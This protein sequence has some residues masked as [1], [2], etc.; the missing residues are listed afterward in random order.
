MWPCILKLKALETKFLILGSNMHDRPKSNVVPGDEMLYFNCIETDLISVKGIR[1]IL[2]V[3]SQKIVH[4]L[5][6]QFHL[7]L[8]Q[9]LWPF[10]SADAGSEKGDFAP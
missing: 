5:H 7:S 10:V 1:Q 9:P 4:L 8:S 2:E 3:K 6:F